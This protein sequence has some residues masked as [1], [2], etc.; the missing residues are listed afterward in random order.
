MPARLKLALLGCGAISHLHIDGIRECAPRIDITA[1]IDT[2]LAKAEE[3]A[4]KTGAAVFTSLRKRS[5]AA[6]S[7]R[8]T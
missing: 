4:A 3:I 7:K 8:S 1:A 2:D 6:T 5:K